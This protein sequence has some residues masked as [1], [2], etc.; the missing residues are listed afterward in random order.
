MKFI[1]IFA[2]IALFIA[3]VSAQSDAGASDTPTDSSLDSPTP[4]SSPSSGT[5]GTQTKPAPIMFIN[6]AGS[7]TSPSTF[8]YGQTVPVS[9]KTDTSYDG[10]QILS[11]WLA[12]GD[13]INNVFKI[14]LI[15]DQFDSKQTFYDWIVQDNGTTTVYST[16]E[17]SKL[18]LLVSVPDHP[19]YNNSYSGVFLLLGPSGSSSVPSGVSSATVGIGNSSSPVHISSA[20]SIGSSPIF[21]LGLILVLATLWF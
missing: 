20:V 3:Y 1:H 17:S 6:P 18:S 13:D 5:S 10:P 7:T 12:S 2:L 15:T 19:E 9:W 21:S 4:S 11:L 16:H 14:A 8:I